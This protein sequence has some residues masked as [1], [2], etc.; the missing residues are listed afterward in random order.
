MV[1]VEAPRSEEQIRET[2]RRLPQPKLINMFHGGKTPLMS[3]QELEAMGYKIVI[4]PSDTQRAA[5]GAMRRVL[6]AIKSDGDSG[7]LVDELASFNDRESIVDTAGYLEAG[8]RF[9]A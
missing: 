6:A 3:A 7:A 5:I 1:F 8:D 9:S 2:A 4:V